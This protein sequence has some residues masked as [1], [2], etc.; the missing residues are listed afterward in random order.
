MGY[1]NQSYDNTNSG[2][3]F[4][5]N[6]KNDKSPDLSGKVNVNGTDFYIGGWYK[7]SKEGKDF[8]SIKVTP[9]DAVR[10]PQQQAPFQQAQTMQNPNFS[11]E[12]NDEIPFGI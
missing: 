11:N 2:V 4:R 1:N 8:I 12:L 3:M 10:R 6:K 9:Q 7:K 5:A